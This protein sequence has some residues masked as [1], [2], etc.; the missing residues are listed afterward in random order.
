MAQDRAAPG[1]A[2]AWAVVTAVRGFGS[3][4]VLQ[5][6]V[7]HSKS[8]LLSLTEEGGCKRRRWHRRWRERRGRLGTGRRPG[9][10]LWLALAMPFPAPR[11]VTLLMLV[12]AGPAC[13]QS[14]RRNF[15][16]APTRSRL[17]RPPARRRR[18]GVSAHV[19]PSLRLKAQALR[20]RGASLFSW[21]D[22]TG[23]LCVA[24]RG[25]FARGPAAAT[26]VLST[27]TCDAWHGPKL[28]S[29]V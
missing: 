19:L 26:C 16:S 2:P 9:L 18:A 25:P 27:R 12:L 21:D 10:G 29:P 4:H 22:A 3:K 5:L 20:T 17:G 11:E 1:E 7:A 13:L 14:T 8:M 15:V 23:T 24:V 28:S 6:Q